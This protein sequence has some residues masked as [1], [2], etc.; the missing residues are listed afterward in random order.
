[1]PAVE[2]LQ[3][4]LTPSGGTIR[5]SGRRKR[6]RS[7]RG[8]RTSKKALA[9]H[10]PRGRS[11]HQ[12]EVDGALEALISVE[13]YRTCTLAPSERHQSADGRLMAVIKREPLQLA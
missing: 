11:E 12:T 6:S 7:Q 1:M 4:L 10:S 9:A 8:G 3:P 5:R 2:P 13:H